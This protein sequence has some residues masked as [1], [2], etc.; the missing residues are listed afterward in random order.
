MAS[1]F[2]ERCQ[3]L[4]TFV[5][6]NMEGSL[7]VTPDR[8]NRA[9]EIACAD[10]GAQFRGR[11]ITDGIEEIC[12]TCYSTRFPSPF[13]EYSQLPQKSVRTNLAAD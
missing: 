2:P 1:E 7:F 10:C 4:G 12:D 6:G 3:M 9:P 13:V 11:R 5:E 8:G